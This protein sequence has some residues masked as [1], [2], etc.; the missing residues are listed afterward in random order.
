MLSS[1]AYLT[2]LLPWAVGPG[3][4]ALHHHHRAI[5]IILSGP[6]SFCYF[7]RYLMAPPFPSPFPISFAAFWLARGSLKEITLLAKFTYKVL[8]WPCLQMSSH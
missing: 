6:N 7:M 5:I 2:Q 1:C 4:S 8:W 3:P